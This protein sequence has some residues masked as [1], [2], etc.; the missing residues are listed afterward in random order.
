MAKKGISRSKLN[1]V[2]KSLPTPVK[3]H[4]KRCKKLANYYVQ[5]VLTE[6]WFIDAGYKAENLV[7]AIFYHDVGKATI[8]KDCI[9]IN[10]CKQKVK[11]EKYYAHV[12][13][14]IAI[15]EKEGGANFFDCKEK[16][17]EK[18]IYNVISDHHER[19]DGNGFPNKKEGREISFEGRLTAVIETFDN[20]LFVGE[21]KEIDFEGA[22]A[23]LREMSGK[24]LDG[25]I[26]E[27]LL[28][29]E[30]ALKDF[31]EFIN[32]RE[33]DNRRKDRYGVQ[34]RYNP[35]LNVIDN[36]LD[37][38][39]TDI[40]INDPYYG[41]IPSHLFVSVAE[42]AG[43]IYQVEKIGFEKLCLNLEK[44]MIRGLEVPEVAYRFSARQLEK[45]NFFK[46][47]KKILNKYA[48]PVNKI[49]IMMTEN[50]LVDYSSDLEK[51]VNGI[52]ELGMRFFIS[53]FGEQLSLISSNESLQI[54]GV[55][56]KT[57][58]G[59]KIAV[60]PKTYG[61]VS[62]VVRIIEKLHSD[63]VLAGISDARAEESTVKMGVKYAV[64]SRYGKALNDKELIAYVKAGG[65]VDG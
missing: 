39:V 50:S 38:F 14:G 64:G 65:G 37:R 8:P 54:D 13:A 45:K 52:H 58:Y 18:T 2:V 61:I 60:N 41:I 51:A 35:V 6:D 56:F 36:V 3:E 46:D 43:S 26:V 48:V 59:K 27:T 9:H 47:I 10:E 34:L 40:V 17:Y 24:E 32:E 23:T 31:I 22:A 30:N 21:K 11:K 7:G 5:R 57:E 4:L 1:N 55:I 29:D 44:L 53:E 16:S 33:K 28:V 25:E 12:S 63:I 62:G 15:C 42:K 49:V 20:L 19:Y